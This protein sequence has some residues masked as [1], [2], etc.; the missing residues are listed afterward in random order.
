MDLPMSWLKEYTDVNV[1]IKEYVE[2]I[3]MSGSKVEGYTTLAGEIKNVV[4]GYIKAIEK[5]PDADK[6][7]ICTIDAGQGKDLI[8]VTGAQNIKVGDYVPVA[9]DGSVIAGGKE[10]NTGALRGVESQGMLCSVEEL[11]C[12]R[13]DFPEAPEHGIYIFPKAVELGKDVVEL[14]D[15]KDVVVE[16]EITSNRPDCFSILGLARETAA[17]Y[18]SEFRYPKITVK[19]EGTGKIEEMIS[20]EIKNSDLCPRY[21][22]RAVKNVKIGP[23]PRWMRK[24]LRA[25]GVRPIN[26]IVDITNY[27][28]LEMG[29]PMHAFNIDCIA[30]RKI[31]VR[32]AKAD[33][34][35]VTLDGVERTLN[36]SMLVIADPEKAVAIAG[37]MGGENSMISEDAEAILFESANFNGP[38]VRITAKNV[39]LRTDASSKYEK[40]LDPNLAIDAV[41]RAVQLVEMLG[42]GE[43]VPGMVD[44]YPNQRKP[45]ELSY[46]PEWINKFLGTE[47]SEKEMQETFE[48]LGMVVD[49]VNHTVIVPTYRPDLE[50]QADLSEEVARFFGYDKIPDTLAAGTPTVGKKNYE[51][52]IT[53]L[54]KDTMIADGLCE[55][56]TY[57]F[58]S[59][60]VFDKLL[61]PA[62]SK[63]RKTVTISNP[64][65]EDF[66]IMRTVSFNG[67]L[68]SLSTNY[69]RRNEQAGLFE[70]ARVYLPKAL[71]LTELP[72]EIPTLTV[73]MYGNMDFYDLKGIVEHLVD[74]LGLAEKAEYL[75]EK[76]TPWMHPGR[77]ACLKINAETVGYFGELHPV[78]AK[79]YEIGT[80]AYMAVLDLEK[81]TAY[82]DRNVTYKPLPKFPGMT[83]DIAMLVKED[84]TVKE[85]SDIIKKNGGEYLESVTLFDVYKGAQ[86]EAGYKSVAYSIS[87]RSAERTLADA[88]ISAAMQAILSGLSTE[89]D[90]QL[91][92]K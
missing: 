66:S 52:T 68:N 23:S 34:K 75:P 88:D 15:I 89:L 26:N 76:E 10:I 30:D 50:A 61:I 74:V 1:G 45:W 7:Q 85:I 72:H 54:V 18:K 81:M 91:R 51:Q 29:Q 24:R 71:P 8:I 21:I 32:N 55:G 6:L 80:K 37:V 36:E 4:S 35:I 43:V 78:V 3:T 67:I 65:G 60:K 13:H 38:N 41:N 20:V 9:L 17:T 47:I 64:L 19:E 59:P 39:G 16:F 56:M 69:N 44:C 53:S 92:D 33:E 31:I 2:D 22:A 46:S 27:V 79:N 48:R 25:A 87:F 28:M 84:V 14:L 11:G 42:I 5:H 63:L 49:P 90:A 70:V 86:I 62:D 58:E 40:G 12:D 82:A 77:T 83:R 73:G 57:S